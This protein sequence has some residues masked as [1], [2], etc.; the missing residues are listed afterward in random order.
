MFSLAPKEAAAVRR[1]RRMLL[2]AG[3]YPSHISYPNGPAP[4]Y[5]RFAVSSEHTAEQVDMLRGVL[6]EFYAGRE[7]A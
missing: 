1:L 6:C 3:I 4:S 7:A 2:E 5:F